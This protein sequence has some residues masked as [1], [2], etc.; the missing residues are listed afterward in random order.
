M[1][2]GIGQVAMTGAAIA[3]LLA[4]SACGSDAKK[5]S[6]AAAATVSS[7][8]AP[9]SAAASA[10]AYVRPGEPA[11]AESSAA[12]SPAAGSELA[13]ARLAVVKHATLGDVVVDAAGFTLYR[14]DKDTATPPT[15]NCAAACAA[16]WPAAVTNGKP[17]AVGVEAALLGTIKRADGTEQV[18][19]GGWPLYRFSADAKAG[20]ANGQAVG[21]V[22]WAVTPTGD[23]VA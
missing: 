21:D 13:V 19:L 3:A 14:F 20:D 8:A 2:R 1:K 16:N 5:D 17:E 9:T 7:T 22:W 23:K 15:S 12:Q 10:P 4:L 11:A 6:S 18:T